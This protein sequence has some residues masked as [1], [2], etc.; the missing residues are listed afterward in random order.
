VNLDFWGYLSDHAIKGGQEP[1]NRRRNSR[2]R[3]K[4]ERYSGAN[5]EMTFLRR[6]LARQNLTVVDV[7]GDGNCQFRAISYARYGTE[8]R[9]EEIRSLVANEMRSN[10]DRYRG[11]HEGDFA[12]FLNEIARPGEWG[13]HASLYAAAVALGRPIN[14]F[15]AD[16][17]V[18][19]VAAN[20]EAPPLTLGILAELHYVSTTSTMVNDVA[21]RPRIP[22]T[23]TMAPD[24][25]EEGVDVAQNVD[26]ISVPVVAAPGVHLSPTLPRPG[27]AEGPEVGF[28]VSDDAPGISDLDSLL[29]DGLVPE[30][31]QNGFSAEDERIPL[32]ILLEWEWEWEWE[33]EQEWEDLGEDQLNDVLDTSPPADDI[34]LDNE[35]SDRFMDDLDYP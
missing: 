5:A 9:H 13:N 16:G 34:A 14:V 6:L 27:A 12:T 11:F 25:V 32:S 19:R 20:L 22:V 30:P 10:P 1:A 24:D 18:M 35:L 31:P 15:R 8:Q 28:P 29:A 21:P 2:K 4:T 3:K 33:W 26:G 17:D 7:Q 23:S